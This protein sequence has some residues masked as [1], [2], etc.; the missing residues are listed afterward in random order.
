VRAIEKASGRQAGSAASGIREK[1]GDGLP[2]PANRPRLHCQ[3]A[4][5]RLALYA[6][7]CSDAVADWGVLRVVK[8]G[9]F[10]LK[11]ILLCF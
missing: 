3:R 4:W 6:H 2:D 7:A 8:E 10:L 5:N 11:A 1:K 9:G